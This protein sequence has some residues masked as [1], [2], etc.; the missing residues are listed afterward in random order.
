MKLTIDIPLDDADIYTLV[1]M[2]V[3]LYQWPA[4]KTVTKKEREAAVKHAII[5][6]VKQEI[7]Y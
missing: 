4:S 2:A 6:V 7:G 1:D 5:G 3:D